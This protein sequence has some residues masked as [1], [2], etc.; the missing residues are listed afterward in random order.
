[1]TDL[2]H[3]L[4]AVVDAENISARTYQCLYAGSRAEDPATALRALA[5][6]TVVVRGEDEVVRLIG[7]RALAIKGLI[8]NGDGM[9]EGTAVPGLHGR[10]KDP[11]DRGVR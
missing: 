2:L 1:M 5:Y 4:R 11:P 3:V 8:A 10:F 9:H 7:N 6:L